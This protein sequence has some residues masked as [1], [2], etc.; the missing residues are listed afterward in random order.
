MSSL[1]QDIRYA[2][3]SA[4]ATPGFA[5]AAVGSIA[6][7]I[8]AN[9][10]LFSVA[11]A[12]LLN[13]LPY[14]DADRLAIVWNRSPGLNIAEDWFSTAQYFDIRNRHSGFE[15]VA[16]AIG[17]NDNLTGD[18]EPERIGTIRMSSNLL[19]MLG[20]RPALGELLTPADDVPGQTGKAL[21]GHTTWVRRYG[22]DPGIL[23][24][25]LIING[26][27]YVIHGVLPA[28]FALPR[29]VMPT[30]NGAEDAEIVLPLP[31]ATD[32]VTFRGREDYN[33]L[34]KLKPGVRVEQA[35]AEMDAITA[36]LRQEHPDLYPPNGG[37]TFDIVPLQEQVVGD[38]RRSVLVLVA[39]VACV[40]L[41]ACANVANLLLSRALARRKEIAVRVSLGAGRSR[42][43][44]QLLTESVMLALAGGAVGLLLALWGV[45]RMR[46]LGQGSVPRLREIGVDADVLAFTLGISI[47]S[48]LVFGLVP[49]LRVTRV[50]LQGQLRDA[51]RTMA[52][53]GALW[54]RGHHTRRAL[55]VAEL[56]L[57]VMLLVGAGLLIR[58][59][60]RL[61]D[62]APGFNPEQTLTMEL[63]MIGRRYVDAETVIQTNR[64]IAE[65]VTTVPGVSASGL[66]SAL[67]LSQMFA[68]GPIT[69]EGRAPQP[70]EAFIN[71]DM[72]FVA[73]AYFQAME[74]PLFRGRLFDDQDTR[75]NPRVAV[76]EQRMADQLWPGRDA[77]GQRV[78]TGGGD[79][80]TPWITVVGV[81]GNV[82]QYTLDGD[83]RMAMYL[84]HTQYPVRAMNLV[85][86]SAQDPASLA[87]AVRQVLRDIDADLPVYR[88]RTMAQR[89]DESLAR[90]RFAVVLLGLFAAIAL[91]LA[92]LGIYGVMAYLVAQ[93]TRELGIRLALGATPR[94]VRRLIISGGMTVALAGIA[95]GLAAAWMVSGVMRALLF[96]VDARD[97]I[98]FVAI[99]VLLAGVAL[100]ACYLPARRAMRIDPAV[101]LRAE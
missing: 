51:A 64:Q 86:R 93:G 68:W 11:N 25:P 71:V 23:G 27:S 89:V 87:V 94:E 95:V 60:V 58:S 56:A 6:I 61:L 37:L 42:I 66:G 14:A 96:G 54:A 35:Q 53:A 31:L 77:I 69:V 75:A 28:S 67:P 46:T 12:L 97:P 8:G 99:P 18:G 47:A 19:P 15:A 74:I 49:A 100:L 39:A 26:Q 63:S 34:G 32:A 101:C 5:A 16:I 81:V 50:D 30:L 40:L 3:R 65:R 7:G 48:G 62:V 83:S 33:V 79:S 20:V 72:R 82:K 88:V 29:E 17:G 90:R 59:F 41:I 92:S 52:G 10:T 57:S 70:G 73:G 91:G 84:A 9:T 38:V 45:D 36:R 44:G 13:P 78:K 21:L 1:L 55:V 43:V 80:K 76:I 24:R 2:L 22:G 85:V 98:T 4:M